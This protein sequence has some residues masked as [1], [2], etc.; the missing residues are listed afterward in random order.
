MTRIFQRRSLCVL[1]F[2]AV[3]SLALAGV[4][5]ATSSSN[6]TVTICVHHNGGGL[7]KA[8]KC[9]HKDTTLSWNTRGLPGA[10][11]ATGSRGPT[12]PP[13]TQGDPGPVTGALPSGVTLTGAW[14]T[15][16]PVPSGGTAEL[17]TTISFPLEPSMAPTVELMTP[18]EPST[19]QCPGS[20][21]DPQAIPGY[22]C[23]YEVE[24]L[25]GPVTYSNPTTNSAGSASQFG[26]NL[27][28][29]SS[30]GPGEFNATG[31]WALT[32]S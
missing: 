10:Q 20:V 11:G 4:A 1:G 31:T 27:T 17:D 26:V 25:G 23:V 3:N 15:V 18:G 30:G 19:T 12:G 7:Y 29:T 13:G 28:E 9:L 8:S 2:A 14:A 6:G 32:G 24:T 16:G 21:S 22:L 5:L